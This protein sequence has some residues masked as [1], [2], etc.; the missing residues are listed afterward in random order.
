MTM[1]NER[2]AEVAEV[3]RKHDL[4]AVEDAVYSFLLGKQRPLADF[5][6]ERTIF[7]ESLSKRVSPGLTLG[8]VVAPPGAAFEKISIAI[9]SGAWNASGFALEFASHWLRTGVIEELEDAK[10]RDAAKRQKIASRALDGLS[11][12]RDERSYHIWLELPERW[13][14]ETFVSASAR[15]GI[16]VTPAATFAVVPGHAPN[17]IRLALASPAPDDLSSA[18]KTIAT[19]CHSEPDMIFAN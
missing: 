9:R 13:R 11:L 5:A 16:A 4:I 2:C 8:F 14:A 10:R 19:I 6:P 1:P 18:L 17:A 15:R 3:L 7:I 12:T